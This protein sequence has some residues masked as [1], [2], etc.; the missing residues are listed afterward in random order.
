MTPH[1]GCSGIRTSPKTEFFDGSLRGRRDFGARLKPPASNA[2]PTR[3]FGRAPSSAVPA[4][5][6]VTLGSAG[7]AGSTVVGLFGGF[8][9]TVDVGRVEVGSDSVVDVPEEPL[10]VEALVVEVSV[11]EV[12]VVEESVVDEI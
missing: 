8:L 10:V 3:S 4:R 9:G 5:S 12:S 1:S 6:G 7:T 11:V 2:W